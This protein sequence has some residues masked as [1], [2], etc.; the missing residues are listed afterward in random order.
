VERALP[1]GD[2]LVLRDLVVERGG[3]KTIQ[4]VLV[5]PD[6]SGTAAEAG[7]WA[8]TPLTEGTSVSQSELPAPRVTR[9]G[10]V[11]TVRQLGTLVQA[12]DVR[13]RRC[14]TGGCG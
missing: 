7:N 1:E 3:M 5:H 11:Y 10:P 12:V 13:A 6:C 8:L 9:T 14:I 4:V 2:L